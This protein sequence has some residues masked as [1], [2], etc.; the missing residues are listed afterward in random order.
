MGG[1]EI[2][3]REESL[4]EEIRKYNPNNP[5][6][7]EVVI[8]KYI[9]PS[10]PWLSYRH[11]F[12]FLKV[13]EDALKDPDYDFASEFAADYDSDDYTCVAW[14]ET[15]IENPRLFFEDIYRILSE[16]W[17]DDIKR[18]EREDPSTW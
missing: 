5:V 1:I 14:D 2:Y 9:V 3:D 15:E 13:L 7:R 8:R 12:V 16:V 4:G 17:C 11:K 6:E 18:A 10:E